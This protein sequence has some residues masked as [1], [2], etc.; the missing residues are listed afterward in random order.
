V[1][2]VDNFSD[3]VHF[4]DDGKAVDFEHCLKNVACCARDGRHNGNLAMAQRVEHTALSDVGPAHNSHVY[5]S[6]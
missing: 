2:I 3:A 4:D 5:A 6:P 1:K